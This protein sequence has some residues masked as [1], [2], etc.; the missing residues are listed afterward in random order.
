MIRGLG[1]HIL[2]LDL[3]SASYKAVLLR[4]GWMGTEWVG[5]NHREIPQGHP[6]FDPSG[7]TRAELK[8]W[9]GQTGFSISRVVVALPAHLVSLRVLSLPFTDPRRIEKVVPFEAEGLIPHPLEEVVVDY[10]VAGTQGGRSRVLVASAPRALVR[11]G[12]TFLAAAGID[13]EAVD[14]NAL[15]LGNLGRFLTPD[16]PDSRASEGGGGTAILDFGASKTDLCIIQAGRP[17]FMRS[18]LF[19]GNRLTATLQEA[20]GISPAEAEEWKRQAGLADEGISRLHQ[21]GV[22]ETIRHALIPLVDEL[23]RTF[24]VVRSEAGR[25]GTGAVD[26]IVVVG[27][28]GKLKGLESHLGAELGIR[29]GT[30]SLKTIMGNG[31]SW[32]PVYGLGLGLALRGGR[33]PE[34]SGINFR[35]GEFSPPREKAAATSRVRNLVVGGLIIA[36]LA[37]ADLWGKYRLQENRYL[38]LKSAVRDQFR[39][40]FPETRNVV[41]EVQQTRTALADLRK[42]SALFGTGEWSPLELMAELTRRVPPSVKIEVQDLLIESG[43]LRLEAETES[44]DSVDKIKDSFSQFKGFKDVNVSDAKVS[45]DQSRVRFRLTMTVVSK[46]PE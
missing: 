17:V 8:D 20:C 23:V 27:G 24:H 10:H 34:G 33:S 31:G 13:P 7:E 25:K 2:G 4:R 35:K 9:L 41:D 39:T 22:S 5:A 1:G 36:A 46:E 44:F 28:G 11:N 45:A 42:K 32:D 37:G 40:M 21:K 29:A 3:G 14:L 38:E 6:L 26:R 19:G 43:R 30:L 16:G 12:L 18:L 15:A